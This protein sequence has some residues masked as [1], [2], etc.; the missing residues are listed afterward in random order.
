[1]LIC[2]L[3]KV[4]RS[5]L[6]SPSGNVMLIN[7]AELRIG[8]RL[9]ASYLFSHHEPAHWDRC[10]V[11]RVAGRRIVLCARC[12]GIYPGIIVGLLTY[13]LLRDFESLLWFVWLLPVPALVDW[14]ISAFT[15]VPSHN[16][17]RTVTG[18]CLGI[19]YGLG[20]MLLL[21][22]AEWA[23]LMAGLLYASLVGVL[24]SVHLAE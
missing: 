22:D 8:L 10:Y 5:T 18:W 11:L 21:I 16:V 15:N 9:T 14:S 2:S 19:G 17:I 12:S 4:N 20:V 3:K 1:M 24:L 6:T 7:W 13:H 23:V